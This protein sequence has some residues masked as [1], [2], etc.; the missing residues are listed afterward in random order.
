[1]AATVPSVHEIC[2]DLIQC[3]DRALYMAKDAGRGQIKS[4]QVGNITHP[5]A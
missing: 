4:M 5:A 2:V 1:V 3:A